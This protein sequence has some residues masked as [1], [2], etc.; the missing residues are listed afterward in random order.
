MAEDVHVFAQEIEFVSHVKLLQNYIVFVANLKHVKVTID[1]REREIYIYVCFLLLWGLLILYKI[2]I[3]SQAFSLKEKKI[4]D[5]YSHP[6][7]IQAI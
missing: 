6:E 3:K 2:P 7:I 1:K 4:Y 5:L